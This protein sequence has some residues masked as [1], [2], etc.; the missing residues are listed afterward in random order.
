MHV[1]PG[2]FHRIRHYGLLAS[3]VRADNIARVREMLAVPLIP[4][5]AIKATTAK[6][7]EPKSPGSMPLLRRPHDHHRDLRA[8]LPAETPDHTGSGGDQDRHI[9]TSSPPIERHY[10]TIPRQNPHSARGIHRPRHRR[11]PPPAI[12]CLGVFR[13]P[14]TG[15]RALSRH[16]GVRKPAQQ[17]TFVHFKFCGCH[18]PSAAK[19]GVDAVDT[20]GRQ[21]RS[22]A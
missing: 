3:A 10:C 4:I 9:M 8:R 13:T 12:S 1:L 18:R 7:D 20:S 14:A 2:G 16:A 22:A 19:L 15:T 17:Q 5:D 11:C 21:A 6:P